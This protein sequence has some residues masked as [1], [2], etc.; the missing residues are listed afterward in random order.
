MKF[1]AYTAL[2]YKQ[3]HMST[4]KQ[5]KPI[6]EQSPISERALYDAKRICTHVPTNLQGLFFEWMKYYCSTIFLKTRQF[7]CMPPKI[8]Q[9]QF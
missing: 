2:K 7:R 3:H 6:N 8:P 1:R 4:E 5:A 9:H